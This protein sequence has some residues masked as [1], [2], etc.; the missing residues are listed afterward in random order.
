VQADMRAAGSHN[1]F[2]AQRLN[3][4][5]PSSSWQVQPANRSIEPDDCSGEQDWA[6]FA[7]TMRRPWAGRAPA[8]AC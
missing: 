3:F 7:A 2:A 8:R 5:A 4:G 1:L 6:A